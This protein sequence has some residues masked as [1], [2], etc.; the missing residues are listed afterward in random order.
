VVFIFSGDI[1]WL[2]GLLLAVGQGIGAFIGAR[3]ILFLPRANLIIR[4]LLII[5]LSVSSVVLLRL[6]LIIWQMFGN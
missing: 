3:Y 4:W 2:P 1:R 6:H 5:I